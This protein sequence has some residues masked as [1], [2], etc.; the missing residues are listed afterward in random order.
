M[1]TVYR[2]EN[3]VIKE[4]AAPDDEVIVRPFTEVAPPV[5]DNLIIKGFDW[6]NSE[7]IVEQVV[8]VALY[9]AQQAGFEELAMIVGEL[10]EEVFPAEE[11]LPEE[12]EPDLP[13]EETEVPV[14]ET[15]DKSEEAE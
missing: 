8:P 1:K 2:V 4:W 13:V 15:A 9:E 14:D 7:Y 3:A 5:A 10:C 6:N 12:E 11:E